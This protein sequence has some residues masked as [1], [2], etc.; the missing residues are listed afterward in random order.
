MLIA[1][2]NSFM[3]KMPKPLS[4]RDYV[5]D[6]ITLLWDG[7]ENADWGVHNAAATTWKNLAGGGWDLDV[8]AAATWNANSIHCDGSAPAAIHNS[9]SA[10]SDYNALALSLATVEIV[11][12]YDRLNERAKLIF[13]VASTTSNGRHFCIDNNTGYLHAISKKA[14][15]NSAGL[16]IALSAL[17]SSGVPMQ[18][19]ADYLTTDM[20]YAPT[21]LSLNNGE[22][23]A[24]SASESRAVDVG[25]AL[26]G[27][28]NFFRLIGD[29]FCV[30]GYSRALTAAEIAANYA[31][32]VARFNLPTT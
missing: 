15:Y 26:G 4:A 24:V 25:I 29:I 5:Q 13:T 18:V 19:S 9:A 30:R 17:P 27:R 14:N 20:R 3:V 11:F 23:Q 10:A 1:A 31:V 7:I 21:R 28:S 22:A 8:T 16:G 12:S 32:D 2:R 6:D